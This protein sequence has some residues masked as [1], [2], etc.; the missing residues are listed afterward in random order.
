MRR[1]SLQDLPDIAQD[2]HAH[3]YDVTMVQRSSTLVVTCDSLIDVDMK[4]VYS[5]D[6]V[7]PTSP[8]LTSLLKTSPPYQQTNP[9]T[10]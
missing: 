8:F 6:G 3:G 1:C 9:N 5:E 4:G 2:Y 7:S 10:H